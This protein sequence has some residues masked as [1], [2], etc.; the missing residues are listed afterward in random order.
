MN[1]DKIPFE[2]DTGVFTAAVGEAIQ[3]M[4]RI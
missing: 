3:N 4:R 1:I 2:R